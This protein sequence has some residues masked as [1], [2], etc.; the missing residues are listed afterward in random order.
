MCTVS[1]IGDAYG[2][3]FPDRWPGAYPWIHPLAPTTTPIIQVPQVTKAEIDALKREVLELRALLLQA[4]KF[5]E[6]T[7]Q[8]ECEVDE[9]VALIRK[10]ADAVGVDMGVVFP[11]G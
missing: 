1:M 9:K 5:D 8:P 6:A 10:I 2:K 4:K 7:G 3:A 11:N